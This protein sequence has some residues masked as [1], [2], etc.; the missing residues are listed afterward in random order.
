VAEV[1]LKGSGE[2][3]AKEGAFV[4]MVRSLRVLVVDQEPTLRLILHRALSSNGHFSRFAWGPE[5]AR[6]AL[7]Q[8]RFDVIVCDVHRSAEAAATLW[9][10]IQ[11]ESGSPPP[12][13]VYLTEPTRL[14][15]SC[16]GFQGLGLVG[17]VKPFR[18]A[19]FL[20]VVERSEGTW[21]ALCY[22]SGHAAPS[23][24]R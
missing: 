10:A 7:V 15:A 16:R 14:C 12:R 22:A 11:G 19:E 24:S 1:L 6:E 17:L 2:G 9:D 13:V 8:E 20:A 21:P 18:L 3:L 5:E 23:S 4:K